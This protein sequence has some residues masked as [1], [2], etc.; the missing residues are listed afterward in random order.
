MASNTEARHSTDSLSSGLH[1]MSE[2]ERLS[3]NDEVETGSIRI[4][5][6]ASRSHAI[7]QATSHLSGP[8]AVEPP[9]EPPLR[10]LTSSKSYREAGD[11][12]Y[13]RFSRKRKTS[14]LLLMS[15]CALLSPISSTTILAAI[16]EVAAEYHTTGSIIDVS[17]ALYMV[18][19]GISPIVWG[20]MS[21]VFGRRPVSASRRLLCCVAITR[22]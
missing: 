1:D 11:E 20:P 8:D 5:P 2:P 14:I 9:T 7:Y 6:V 16:P 15:Y 3:T 12:V 18:F 17:N 10:Q 21:Q 22:L 19:M 13:D 4:E